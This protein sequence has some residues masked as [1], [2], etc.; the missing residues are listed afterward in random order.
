[1]ASFDNK[2]NPHNAAHW[3]QMDEL[4]AADEKKKLLEAIIKS[5]T[6]KFYAFTSM[7]RLTNT[8]NKITVQKK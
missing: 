1:M 5:D 4:F 6:E 8:L 2:L 7:L 3:Q